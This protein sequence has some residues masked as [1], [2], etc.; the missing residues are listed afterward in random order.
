MAHTDKSNLVL[1]LRQDENEL[2]VIAELARNHHQTIEILQVFDK[3]DTREYALKRLFEIA[4]IAHGD[5]QYDRGY[6]S[7][8][9]EK[10]LHPEPLPCTKTVPDKIQE[11]KPHKK[12]KFL[13]LAF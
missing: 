11:K 13:G 5:G 10:D 9:P 8:F 6:N 2:Y 3:E 1:T 4:Q 12:H 7:V